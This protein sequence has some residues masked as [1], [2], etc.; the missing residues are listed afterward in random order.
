MTTT[1]TSPTRLMTIAEFEAL[2]EDGQKHELLWGELISVASNFRQMALTG[3]LVAALSTYVDEH[4]LGIVGPE[5]TFEF[6][7]DLP[8]VLVPDVAFVRTENIP[9]QDQ[10][11]KGNIHV[12]PDLVIEVI[13]PSETPRTIQRKS[14][15]YLGQ[16]V[17]MVVIVYPERHEITLWSSEATPRYLGREDTLDFGDVV[18]GFSLSLVH[19]FR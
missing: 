5:G 13:S 4:D 2:P 12:V 9:P 11:A 18:P 7:T 19:L 8:L 17:R 3:R 1:T 16:G 10:Q 6:K 14:T 15:A